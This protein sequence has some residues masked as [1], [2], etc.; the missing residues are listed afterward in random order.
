ME[1]GLEP[2]ILGKVPT[3]K[4]YAHLYSKSPVAHI[5]KVQT[6]TLVL[7]GQVDRR[8]PPSQGIEYHN[9]LKAKGVPTKY[10]IF[11]TLLASLNPYACYA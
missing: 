7:H 1:A 8:V 10:D 9:A 2:Y 5:D 4:V 3:D 6:P 11:F